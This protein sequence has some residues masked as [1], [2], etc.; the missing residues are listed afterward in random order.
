[1]SGSRPTVGIRISAEGAE[2][3]KRQLEALGPAGERAFAQIQAAS[4]NSQPE[5]QK[6]GT[7]VDVVQRAFIGMGGSLGS[8]GSVFTGVSAVAG[9]LTT[10]IVAL[11]AAAATSA[12]AIAKAGDEANATLARLA[13]ATGGAA[14]ATQVYEQ[15]FKLSQQTGIAVAESAGA[16]SRFAVAAKEIGGTNAQVLQLVGGIQKA[17]IV[18]G[19]S[20]TETG[21]AVQQLGQALASG[22]LQG[23]ELRSLLENMPQLAQKLAQELGVG[24]GQLRQMG[25][26]GKLTADVVFPALLRATEKIGAEFDKMPVTMSRAKDILIAATEDFGAR[27]D[28]ITGLSQTFARFMQQGAAVL[29]A[30]GRVIAPNEREAAEDEL[31]RARRRLTELRA[32]AQRDPRGPLFQMSGDDSL[33]PRGPDLSRWSDRQSALTNE[34]VGSSLRL[35]RASGRSEGGSA[36]ERRAELQIPGRDPLDTTRQRF[37]IAPGGRDAVGDRARELAETE[38]AEV[39]AQKRLAEILARGA[40]QIEMEQEQAARQALAARRARLASEVQDAVEFGDQRVKIARETREKLKKIDEA[41]AAGVTV[42]RDG[43]P[44]DATRARA[45]VL[46][47]QA[48]ALEKLAKEEAKGGEE[49]RKAAEKRQDVID[50]LNEQVKAAERSIASTQAGG[51]ASHELSIA[52][53]IENKLREAGIPAIEKRTEAE[54]K[55]ADQITASV[56]ALDKLKDAQKKADDEAKKLKDFQN[57]SLNELAAIGERAMDRLA[58]AMVQAFVEGKGAALSFGNVTKAILASVVTDFAKLAIVN[59]IMNSLFVGTNGPRPT[60]AGAFGSGVSGAAGFGLG[61]ALG[62][63]S[64]AN[65]LPGGGIG[66]AFT[67]AS[68]YLFGTPTTYAIVDPTG[69][70]SA[71]AGTPGVFGTGGAWT[72]GGVAGAAGLGFGAGQLVNAI[73]GGNQLGGTVGSALGTGAGLAAA[74]ALNLAVPGLGTALAIFGGAAGGGIGGLFGPGESSRGWSYAIR[75]TG[76]NDGWAFGK[77]LQLTD[78]YYNESGRAA[79]EE[80]TANIAAINTYLSQRGL[81]V[82]GARAV[83]GTKDGPG[84]LGYGEALSFNEAFSSLRFRASNDNTL[85]T[86][87]NDRSFADPGALQQFV[88]GFTAVRDTIRNLTETPAQKLARQLEAVGKQF[89]DLSAKAKEY[90]LSEEGLADAR[91]K[92]LDAVK[93]QQ[94]NEAQPIRAYLARLDVADPTRAPVDRFGSAQSQFDADLAA[95]RA[96]DKAALGRITGSADTL[97]GAGRTMY[98]SGPEFAALRAM[99]TSSL[100]GLADQI[101]VDA[102]SIAMAETATNTAQTV[103]AVKAA[104]TTIQRTNTILAQI[105]EAQHFGGAENGGM[106]AAL[107]A[108]FAGGNVIPFARGGIPDL[109]NSPTYAPM[110]LFGE[111]GP[112]AIMPLRRGADGRLGVEM[113]GGG[114]GA[115]AGVLESL[116]MQVNSLREELRTARLRAA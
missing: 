69:I 94:N 95:A 72:L 64:L 62:L 79:F 112:E 76:G 111:A 65:Y 42:L 14:Q 6:L 4:R 24:I 80:A 52:L 37:G 85:A 107:G 97:L 100:S 109:V 78:P 106:Q 89:D 73:A 61:D 35:P 87:L 28:R 56:R 86:A 15:L 104:E 10:A 68:N 57:R 1:M 38:A 11:G 103:Q 53:E 99:V 41:E 114:F 88:E 7:S 26:E 63:T 16:F 82:Y 8:V 74:W 12:V 113:S 105:Y 46:R 13:S 20:A 49:A 59:P 31:Q 67:G 91:Q 66:G 27:L 116:T 43:T 30:A 39:A 90:G 34:P 58:D 60:L 32:D 84:G 2:Q 23:D 55:A 54:K 5:F 47:E 18:A 21:A 44:F 45:G 77:G 110:A 19:A 33:L 40:E 98:A 115:L 81:E 108:V 92:A 22:K 83:G 25:S 102:A 75:A 29:S 93:A 70:P 9:G 17:G 36:A 50:K 3:V 96:G 48:E 51:T 71:V 101:E